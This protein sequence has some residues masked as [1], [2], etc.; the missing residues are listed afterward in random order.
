M[1]QNIV[2]DCHLVSFEAIF[3]DVTQG[4]LIGAQETEYLHGQE[5]RPPRTWTC[6]PLLKLTW[7]S[8]RGLPL[9][10]PVPGRFVQLLESGS[11]LLG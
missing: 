1:W 5:A 10:V 3:Q 9:L 11:P 8:A 6:N 7:L 2:F 4:I